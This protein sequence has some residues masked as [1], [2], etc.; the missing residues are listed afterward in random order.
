MFEGLGYQPCSDVA[1]D[2]AVHGCLEVVPAH[3]RLRDQ[4]YQHCSLN[5]S[6]E[7]Y[8]ARSAIEKWVRLIV[9]AHIVIAAGTIAL[10][11]VWSASI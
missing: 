6:G 4:K 5:C 8:L 9:A 11:M 1:N 7:S 3:F 2:D 10:K